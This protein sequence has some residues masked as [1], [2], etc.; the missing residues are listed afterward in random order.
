[1]KQGQR[2][3]SFGRKDKHTKMVLKWLCLERS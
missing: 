2:P 1:M 3:A